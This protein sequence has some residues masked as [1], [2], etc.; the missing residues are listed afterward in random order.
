MQFDTLVNYVLV[1]QLSEFP[2]YRRHH[3]VGS[4]YQDRLQSDSVQV[5][6]YFQSD[7]SSSDD[8]GIADIALQRHAA[9]PVSVRDGPESLYQF[10]I[11][12]RYPRL[13]RG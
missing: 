13:E 11:D 10:R 4:L 12:P 2:V 9:Y 5:F 8:C 3:L 7:E 1:E 6:R